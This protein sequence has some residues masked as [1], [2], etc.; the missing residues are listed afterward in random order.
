M[1]QN[2]VLL[3]LF[4]ESQLCNHGKFFSTLSLMDQIFLCLVV[5]SDVLYW[6]EV[7][8]NNFMLSSL[9]YHIWAIVG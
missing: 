7:R 4:L 3:L 8:I 5:E 2:S 6:V 1:K 9:M